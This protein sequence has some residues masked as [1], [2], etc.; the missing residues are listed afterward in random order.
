[1]SKPTRRFESKTVNIDR[2]TALKSIGLGIGASGFMGLA[3]AGPGN[4]EAPFEAQRRAVTSAT[5]KYRNMQEALDDGFEIMGPYVPD[6]GW[7]LSHFGRIERAAK[8]G[9]DIRKPQGLVY[10]LERKLGSVEYIVP[11]PTDENGEPID[12]KPDIF[13][14]EGEDLKTPEEHGWHPHPA[15]QH[16]FA[17]DLEDPADSSDNNAD[18]HSLDDLLTSTNWA[19]FGGGLGTS[20]DPSLQPN[21]DLSADWGLDRENPDETRTIDF[22]IEHDDWWTLHGW[23]HFENPEGVFAPFNH[24]PEWDPLYPPPHH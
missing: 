5:R 6:M 19:E 10:N 12:P 22:L 21:D 24:N 3:S 7:H 2:R 11:T 15:A 18:A 4:D 20:P 8:R 16:I 9:I 23:F 14:D 13:N 17:D 1:M